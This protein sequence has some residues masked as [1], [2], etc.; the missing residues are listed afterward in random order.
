MPARPWGTP[1]GHLSHWEL[2]VHHHQDI[3]RHGLA[4]SMQS[5]ATQSMQPVSPEKLRMGAV[6][7]ASRIPSL[8]IGE[9]ASAVDVP[10][11]SDD[12]PASS[13]QLRGR[14]EQLTWA[15]RDP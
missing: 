5:D 14:L 8:A 3:Q 10:R 7:A 2:A 4:C 11:A 6:T 13:P 9:E 12:H 15:E 1:P